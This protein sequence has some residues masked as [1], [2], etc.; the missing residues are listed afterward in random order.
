MTKELQSLINFLQL[1]NKFKNLKR[2]IYVGNSDPK[3]FENDAEHTYELA[4]CAWYLIESNK[5]DL[6]IDKVLKYALVH[7]LPEIYAGD[8]D[9]YL[10]ADK[11]NYEEMKAKGEKIALDKLQ[12]EF[13]DV[14]NLFNYLKTY[15]QKADPESRFIYVLDKLLSHLN[16]T[17]VNYETH[18]DCGISQE[19]ILKTRETKMLKDEFCLSL[20]DEMLAKWDSIPNFFAETDFVPEYK[21]EFFAAQQ[22]SLNQNSITPTI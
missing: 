7:D 13:S 14:P 1:I 22:V 3:R 11:A 15:E 4:I 17:E 2:T 21:K 20:F 8:F 5:L 16:V 12:D 9:P 6:N 18:A 10:F 19:S